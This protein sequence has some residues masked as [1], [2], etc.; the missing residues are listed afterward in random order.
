MYHQQ[1]QQQQ[2]R[3]RFIIYLISNHND[4]NNNNQQKQPIGLIHSHEI[5]GGNND[6]RRIVNHNNSNEHRLHIQPF[7][8]QH[9]TSVELEQMINRND[10]NVIHFESKDVDRNMLELSMDNDLGH[11]FHWLLR[12]PCMILINSIIRLHLDSGVYRKVATAA[13]S[14]VITG[15]KEIF[16]INDAQLCFESSSFHSRCSFSV[17]SPK[18]GG[19]INLYTKSNFVKQITSIENNQQQRRQQI[20]SIFYCSSNNTTTTIATNNNGGGTAA[21]NVKN[22]VIGNIPENYPKPTSSSV[23]GGKNEP[24]YLIYYDDKHQTKLVAIVCGK[25][26]PFSPTDSMNNNNIVTEFNPGQILRM[27]D[28]TLELRNDLCNEQN[29]KDWFY[30]CKHSSLIRVRFMA[31]VYV[32]SLQP[33]KCYFKSS[34]TVPPKKFSIVIAGYVGIIGH[35]KPTVLDDYYNASKVI[36]GG[37]RDH[38]VEII[39]DE[40]CL[41]FIGDHFMLLM[42]KESRNSTTAAADNVVLKM[43]MKN[44]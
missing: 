6:E 21:S 8:E 27:P 25:I 3:R 18:F 7:D 34:L 20:A 29:R 22:I 36:S 1:Q 37:T 44:K 12:S 42:A 2:P 40:D 38:L 11:H 24:D 14:N 33:T 41:V 32:H 26:E 19:I 9:P 30:L 31:N 23:G 35:H 17:D 39:V 43:E 15:M 28:T 13:D 10:F 16:L 5:I 4:T